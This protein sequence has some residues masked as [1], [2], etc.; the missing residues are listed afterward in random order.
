MM[1]R[2]FSFG[3]SLWCTRAGQLF[4][5]GISP[6]GDNEGSGLDERWCYCPAD[7]DVGCFDDDPPPPNISFLHGDLLVRSLPAL[8]FPVWVGVTIYWLRR[9]GLKRGQVSDGKR[10]VPVVLS[11]EAEPIYRVSEESLS[12]S[13]KA[14]HGL[15]CMK[16]PYEFFCQ[17]LRE[18]AF[19]ELNR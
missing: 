12:H 5:W 1:D 6:H 8:T 16:C 17:S 19:D 9:M 18:V 15:K 4:E 3:W 7:A 10:T 13:V 11:D 2:P 14:V